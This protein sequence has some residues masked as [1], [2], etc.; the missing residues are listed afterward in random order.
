MQ[1]RLL[2]QK[3]IRGSSSKS[4]LV[5]ASLEG[6]ANIFSSIPD[7]KIKIVEDVGTGVVEV[8]LVKALVDSPN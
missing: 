7:P 8:R 6:N 5:V 4:E 1:V 2:F 3:E